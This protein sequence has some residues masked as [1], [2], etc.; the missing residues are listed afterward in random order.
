MASGA[1]EQMKE[2]LSEEGQQLLHIQLDSIMKKLMRHSGNPRKRAELQDQVEQIARLLALHFHFVKN[3]NQDG[4]CFEY[5]QIRF[6]YL[7]GFA[8]MRCFYRKKRHK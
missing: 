2:F 3:S 5:S 4:L 1:K 6:L 7:R 8:F